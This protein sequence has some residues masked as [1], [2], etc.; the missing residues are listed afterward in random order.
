[1]AVCELLSAVRTK[2]HENKELQQGIRRAFERT[3]LPNKEKSKRLTA[4]LK[5][6]DGEPLAEQPV[7]PKRATC[8]SVL[9]YRTYGGTQRSSPLGFRL[10]ESCI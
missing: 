1:M 6:H 7:D 5:L 4:L 9:G 8:A 3:V 2:F 10:V